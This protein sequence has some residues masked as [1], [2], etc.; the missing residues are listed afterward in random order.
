M[1]REDNFKATVYKFTLAGIDKLL[2]A[3][4]KNIFHA[5]KVVI[6]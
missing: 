4:N 6:Y 5:I 3:Q 2:F 1:S